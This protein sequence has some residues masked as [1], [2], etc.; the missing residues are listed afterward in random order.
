MQELYD[1]LAITNLSTVLL[2]PDAVHDL[3]AWSDILSHATSIWDGVKRTA[4]SQ[5]DLFGGISSVR[6][7]QSSSQTRAGGGLVRHGK[8]QSCKEFGQ[9]INGLCT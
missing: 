4:T 2:S 8:T 9:P 6:M 1:N 5:L 3:A 7:G